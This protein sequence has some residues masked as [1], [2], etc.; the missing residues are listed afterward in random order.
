M[1]KILLLVLATM[2][3]TSC[4]DKFCETYKEAAFWPDRAYVESEYFMDAARDMFGA[5]HY[6]DMH[7]DE[8]SRIRAR[9]V[10]QKDRFNQILKEMDSFSLKLALASENN[11]K[12]KAAQDI[13]RKQKYEVEYIVKQCILYVEDINKC[14]LDTYRKHRN[15]L[16]E[17]N[18]QID[19][20]YIQA[21]KAGQNPFK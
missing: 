16:K 14:D 5:D 2:L 6:S 20:D 11:E 13:Y 15:N 8:R 12:K 21:I 7:Y 18:E 3:L 9:Y 1:K 19:R 4:K 17:L 10:D